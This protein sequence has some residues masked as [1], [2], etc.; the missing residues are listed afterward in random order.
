[1]TRHLLTALTMLSTVSLTA[2]GVV[3]EQTFKVEKFEH[4]R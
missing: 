4:Q 2:P 3:H 1:M